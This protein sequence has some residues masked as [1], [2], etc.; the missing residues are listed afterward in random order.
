L[1][2]L[3]AY[4]SA[5]LGRRKGYEDIAA[6][7][8]YLVDAD[9]SG[10]GLNA[11]LQI[12]AC[13]TYRRRSQ[14]LAP[15]SDESRVAPHVVGMLLTV[16]ALVVCS[17]PVLFLLQRI[18]TMEIIGVLG[19]PLLIGSLL[20]LAATVRSATGFLPLLESWIGVKPT[21]TKTAPPPPDHTLPSS[22][23]LDE[24]QTGGGEKGN[25][26]S[27][28]E[29]LQKQSRSKRKKMRSRKNR[30]TRILR[31]EPFSDY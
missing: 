13:G 5:T 12:R 29:R 30:R 18:K 20:L 4:F 17:C 28:R 15:F 25:R 19:P 24:K 10:F 23:P 22:E 1:W 14:L 8:T 16:T 21:A 9:G 6:C 27:K 31:S 7:V 11:Y 3:P 26:K 2:D